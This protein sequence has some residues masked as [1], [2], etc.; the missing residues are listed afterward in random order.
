M[1]SEYRSKVTSAMQGTTQEGGRDPGDWIVKHSVRSLRNEY[2]SK[3]MEA[4]D[5]AI[6]D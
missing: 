1:V 5:K 4:R 6:S 3:Q 2:A